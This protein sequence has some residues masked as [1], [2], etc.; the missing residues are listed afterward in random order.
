MIEQL[1]LLLAGAIA[2]GVTMYVLL[3]GFDLGV[4]ILFPFADTEDDR[5]RMMNSLAPIWDG[6]ETWLVLGGAVLFGAFPKAFAILTS[7]FYLPIML[8]LIALV[9]RGVAFEYRFKFEDRRWWNLAFFAG[10]LLAAFAQG[11]VLGAYVQGAT[12]PDHQFHWLGI[13]P[14][15]T[16]VAVV[17]AY[18]MLG[19]A[20][21]VMKTDGPLAIL[22]R[23]RARGLL[24]AS[25]VC[26]LLV[27]VWTP[28]LEPEIAA[29][30]FSFPNLFVLAPIP[31][32]TALTGWL[33]WI[34]L[35]D[36]SHDALAFVAAV[37]LFLLTLSGLAISLWPWI[38]PRSLTIGQAASPPESQVFLA[39]GL[40]AILPF[41]L[42]YTAH[43]YWVFRGKVPTGSGYH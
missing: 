15:F 36:D 34:G 31:V 6:N 38:V 25:L 9:F 10:S 2:F 26:V 8:M 32:T 40:A 13:F 29:R 7:A 19:A 16:G 30:W 4:G 42:A 14:L 28:L 5:D 35:R 1:P 3:D 18:A 11:V 33:V 23:R 43:N 41:V 12:G 39:V 24:V 37:G 27:S 22:M 20:W 21:L 17:I